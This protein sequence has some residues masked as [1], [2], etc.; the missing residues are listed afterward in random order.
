MPE[1]TIERAGREM[2]PKKAAELV[3]NGFKVS[4]LAF[5]T[6]FYAEIRYAA[7]ADDG[8]YA[9]VRFGPLAPMDAAGAALARAVAGGGG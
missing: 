9:K 2:S 7:G 6:D 4:V 8:P 3:A 5:P 1:I